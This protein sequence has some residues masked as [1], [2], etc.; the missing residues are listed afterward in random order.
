MAGL[1]KNVCYNFFE[2]MCVIILKLKYITIKLRFKNEFK[3]CNL[4]DLS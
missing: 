2:E 4:I 3:I 1:L